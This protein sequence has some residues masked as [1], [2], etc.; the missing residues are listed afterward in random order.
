MR[1]ENNDSP[2]LT[3][4][5]HHTEDGGLRLSATPLRLL[6]LLGFVFVRLPASEVHFVYLHLAFKGGRVVLIEKGADF[7]ENV[8]RSLLRYLNISFE[9]VGGYA[10]LVAADKIHSHKPLL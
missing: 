6:R 5:C 2:R 3:H 9:L 1:V 7:M 8:L 10:L 4:P